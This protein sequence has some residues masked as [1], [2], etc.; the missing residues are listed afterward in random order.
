MSLETMTKLFT[1]TVGVGGTASVTFSNIPQNY[2]DLKLVILGRDDRSGQ[3]NG[4]FS[5]QIGFGGTINTGSIYTSKRMG[6]NG[7]SAFSDGGTSTSMSLGMLTSATATTN[8][9]GSNEV[10][11]S[12]YSGNSFKSISCEGASENNATTAFITLNAGLISTSSPITDIKISSTFGTILNQHTIVTLYGIKNAAKTAGNSIKATGG[13]I[14]FDGTYVYHIFPATGTFTPTQ[15]LTADALVIAG[16][17]GGAHGGGGAGGLLGFANQSLITQNYAVTV[18]SGGAAG[19]GT[20]KGTTGNDSQFGALTLV[21]GGGGAGVGGT[22]TPLRNDGLTGGS[23]GGGAPSGASA[24]L[25]G[26]ATS[27]QGNAGG[28]AG[29]GAGSYPG[30]GGGGAGAVGGLGINAVGGGAGGIGSSAYSSW[31]VATGQGQN[32]SGTYYFAG[33]GGAGADFGAGAG[34]LGGGG[35]GATFTPTAG[36]ANTGGGGGGSSNVAAG[37]G[38]SGLVIIRYKG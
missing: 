34:G 30:G 7:G 6:G 32:V 2:T 19:P 28:N 9:F 29:T 8:A 21:K 18:G 5:L 3:P 20:T 12:S 26:S 14:V 23:G 33:G 27:G 13:N 25:G 31:G 11:I 15:N 10:Y 35:A 1:T 37:A 4:D 22:Y 36:T 24:G 16:G 17:G 38:G